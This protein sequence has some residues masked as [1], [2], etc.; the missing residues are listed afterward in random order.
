LNRI[1][2]R[3]CY[4]AELLL[5]LCLWGFGI[6]WS[7]L[8]M[9]VV[10]ARDSFI[11]LFGSETFCKVHI[12]KFEMWGIPAGKRTSAAKAAIALQMCGTAEAVPLT[13]QICDAA[14]LPCSLFKATILS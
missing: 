2:S 1:A 9:T 14:W 4:F 11:H 10:R 13:R 6:L 12:T 5:I 8:G 3:R 7:S